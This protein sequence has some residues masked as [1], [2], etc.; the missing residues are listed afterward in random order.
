MKRI[1]TAAALGV[2]A[3]VFS[4][5]AAGGSCQDDRGGTQP[6]K[7]TNPTVAAKPVREVIVRTETFDTVGKR[8]S[9]KILLVMTCFQADGRIAIHYDKSGTPGRS[10]IV[11]DER[12]PNAYH[13][14]LAPGVVSCSMN[15]TLLGKKNE[16]LMIYLIEGSNE[17]PHSRHIGKIT[18]VGPNGNG[19]T[20]VNTFYNVTV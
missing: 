1:I 10:P 18:V 12:T 17:V 9:R 16:Q 7:H 5:G 14:Q 15:A 6:P 11:T 2:A 13:L 4:T 19:A 3:L 20:H 8:S